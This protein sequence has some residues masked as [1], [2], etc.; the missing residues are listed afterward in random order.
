MENTA[1]TAR[2]GQLSESVRNALTPLIRSDYVLLDCPYHYNIGDSLIWQGEMDFLSSLPFRRLGHSSMLTY[3]DRTPIAPETTILLHGGGNF[4]DV[5][6]KHSL[7]RRRIVESHPDNPI[8]VLPQTVFY[9]D[10]AV[11]RDDADAFARHPNLTICARDRRS[12]ELLKENFRNEILLVPDMAFC[13]DT[14]ALAKHKSEPAKGLL[15]LERKDH[16]L[17]AGSH[18]PAGAEVRDWPASNKWSA[19]GLTMFILRG[20]SI[21]FNSGAD[22]FSLGM[23]AK[24][25][26]A[27]D[28]FAL[29]RFLPH[30]VRT[31]V[32]FISSYREICTTRLHGAILALLL[33]HPFRL[34]DNNYGKNS[35]FFH[36][37]LEN[38]PGA[39]IM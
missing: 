34:I 35:G 19:T 12:Y 21:A 7:F 1:A 4:G 30:A 2:I 31:G 27:T 23:Y 14:G 15:Y 26:A 25:A 37:W 13:I 22:I 10:P 9:T 32:R 24:A 29:D 28:N 5:W 11:M 36:T 33:G 18:I 3:D 16:E 8:I 20:S 6:R 17:A 38:L 39:E